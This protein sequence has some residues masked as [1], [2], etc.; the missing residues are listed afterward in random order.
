[1]KSR[2]VACPSCSRHVR[3]GER[4][5]PFCA[6]EQPPASAVPPLFPRPPRGLSRQGVARFN[7]AVRV[8]ASVGTGACFTVAAIV[9]ACGDA[10]SLQDDG[11]TDSGTGDSSTD[12]GSTDDVFLVETAYGLVPADAFEFDEMSAD[13]PDSGTGEE[14]SVEGGPVEAAR[15][16]STDTADG[17]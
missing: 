9:S 13:A 5:C 8:V 7:A 6:A 16:T 10:T 12:D 3:L 15:D 11:G 4:A 2:L 1:M 17:G 14:S